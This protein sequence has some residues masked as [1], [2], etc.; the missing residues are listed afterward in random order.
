M[1]MTTTDPNPK[2]GA[3]AAAQNR[4]PDPKRVTHHR[5]HHLQ[6]TQTHLSESCGDIKR[7]SSTTI[8]TNIEIERAQIQLRCKMAVSAKL[9]MRPNL[10]L[11]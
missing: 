3:E 7:T 2:A 4:S 1:A 9:A 11:E 10:H 5:C 6:P 8:A